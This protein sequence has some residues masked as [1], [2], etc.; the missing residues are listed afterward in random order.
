MKKLFDFFKNLGKKEVVVVESTVTNENVVVETSSVVESQITDA[1]TT[2]NPIVTET[3]PSVEKP[4]KKG[5][6]KKK[7]E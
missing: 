3:V 4:K 5:G 1:V 6:R 7:V 2:T